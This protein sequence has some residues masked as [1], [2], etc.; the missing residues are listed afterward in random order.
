[1]YKSKYPIE[2]KPDKF[3]AGEVHKLPTDLSI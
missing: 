2:G 3:C 1:M